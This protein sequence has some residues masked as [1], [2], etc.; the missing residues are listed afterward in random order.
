VFLKTQIEKKVLKKA[1]KLLIYINAKTNNNSQMTSTFIQMPNGG[2]SN[3][4]LHENRNEEDDDQEIK[5]VLSYI[6][7]NS[8]ENK[9]NSKEIIEI[10][11]KPQINNIKIKNLT[12]SI[13]NK[14]R[15]IP[16][17]SSNMN[18]FRIPERVHNPFIKNIVGICK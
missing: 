8:N 13:E 5:N 18:S 16:I 6:D 10:L 4:I 1:N 15:I 3:K 11:K 12:P 2:M 9:H 17:V 7:N 14:Y